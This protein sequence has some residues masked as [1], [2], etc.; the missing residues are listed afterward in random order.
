MCPAPAIA[1]RNQ[2]RLFLPAAVLADYDMKMGSFD[3]PGDEG[4]MNVDILPDRP[5]RLVCDSCRC[6]EGLDGFNNC[7]RISWHKMQSGRWEVITYVT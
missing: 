5:G 1:S 3:C 4:S 7:I 2:Y 6:S